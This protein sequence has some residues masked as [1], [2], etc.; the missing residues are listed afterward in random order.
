MLCFLS[1]VILASNFDQKFFYLQILFFILCPLTFI[2]CF[3]LKT[4]IF[5]IFY[6]FLILGSF[7]FKYSFPNFNENHIS[8][9]NGQKITFQG[10]I[11]KEV[12]ARRDQTKLTICAENFFH[13]QKYKKLKGLV[14]ISIPRYPEYRYGDILEISG[15]L[16]KPEIIEDFAYDK[17]LA[18]YKIYS[19]IYSPQIKNLHKNKGDFFYKN[20]F[21]FKKYVENRL[22]QLFPEPHASFEAGL[23]TGSRKGIPDNLMQDFN[24]TGLTH[25]IAISGYNITLVIVLISG[26][27]SF[28]HRKTQII[29]SSITIIVF[30]IFVGASAA[31]I[32]AGIMGVIGLLAIWFGRKSVIAITLI[33]TAFLMTLLNPK[34][35]VYDVGFQLSFLATIGLIYASPKLGKILKL[36]NILG[37]R[38]SFL[39]TMSA[40]VTAVPIIL[41]NFGRLSLISPLAN[42]LVAP[43]IPIA[44]MFGAFAFLGSILNF[45]LGKILSLPAFL[46]LELMMKFTHF[47]AQIPYASI[48]VPWVNEIIL[49]IYYAGLCF[50]LFKGE[51]NN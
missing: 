37:I 40:Q 9:Y 25:I 26:L 46:S 23:I 1:G 11:C 10:R 30:V 5:L 29:C 39:M 20:I 4:K 24:T 31:V 27:L 48:N 15:E 19:V 50:W 35:L 34:I 36:P 42:I 12:D 47:C 45:T 7:C 14:L 28:L 32:R 43:L 8:F 3:K 13:N 22:N 33:F 2:I 49:V 38:E 51:K 44:M 17:Y 18:R 16:I 6:I 21:E 41:L